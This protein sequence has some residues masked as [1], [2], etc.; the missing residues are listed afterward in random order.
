[1]Y[2]PVTTE[3][4]PAAVSCAGLRTA[5]AHSQ[6]HVARGDR[7]EVRGERREARGE[8]REARGERREERGERRE[9]RGVRWVRG[10]GRGGGGG[11]GDGGRGDEGG[12]GA[13]RGEGERVQSDFTAMHCP[14]PLEDCLAY[15]ARLSA[16]FAK[17][18]CIQC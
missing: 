3:G 15:N 7:R 1:M 14:P 6:Y 18:P 13:E 10:E 2:A 17:T 8:R 9:A 4:I 11:G 5:P 12:E 16:S